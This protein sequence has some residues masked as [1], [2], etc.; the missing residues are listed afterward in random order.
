MG[1]D[2]NFATA[3]SAVPCGSAQ[4]WANLGS[5]PKNSR[6]AACAT[7]RLRS[8]PLRR[9]RPTCLDLNSCFATISCTTKAEH[10]LALASEISAR[11]VQYGLT[12]TSGKHKTII[13]LFLK[14]PLSSSIT[15][16]KQ[17]KYLI[18]NNFMTKLPSEF[19]LNP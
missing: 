8:H 9:L 10:P 16:I 15:F 3:L 11:G 4:G 2:T 6:T 1:S 13:F 7:A 18:K 5:D 14:R 12:A 17:A 19:I